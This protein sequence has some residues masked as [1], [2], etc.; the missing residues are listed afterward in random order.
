MTL[1]DV[2]STPAMRR[3]TM[4][5]DIWLVGRPPIKQADRVGFVP[6]P[7]TQILPAGRLQDV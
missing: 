3:R 7:V 1:I 4:V 2:P 6:G 5:P